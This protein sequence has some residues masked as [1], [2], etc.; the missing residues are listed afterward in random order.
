MHVRT[1]GKATVDERTC[2]IDAPAERRDEALDQDEYF[3]RVGEVDRGFLEAPVALDPDTPGAVHHDLGHTIIAQ[4]G[5]EVSETEQSVFE[6]AFE[7]PEL[8]RRDDQALV[9]ERLA[10]RR[11]K[12]V[13]TWSAV[14]RFTKARNDTALDTGARRDRH[15]ASIAMISASPS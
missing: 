15:D 13:A 4:Q 2:E 7:K 9:D 14:R 8:A 11:R 3:L 12:L 5:R 6:P 1:I 10:Q